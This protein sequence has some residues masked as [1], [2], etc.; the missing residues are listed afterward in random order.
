MQIRG[1]WINGRPRLRERVMSF[2][3][4]LMALIFL[5]LIC[6][7]YGNTLWTVRTLRTL[8]N[9]YNPRKV[10]FTLILFLEKVWG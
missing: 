2:Y 3:S 1:Y 8:L 7:F 6:R 4:G 10:L 5:S 9:A